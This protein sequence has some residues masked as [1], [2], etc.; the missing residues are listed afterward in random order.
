MSGKRKIAI[1]GASGS[2]G[3]NALR[4][5]RKN[6]DTLEIVAIAGGSRVEPLVEIAQEFSVPE[7]TVFDS[8]NQ[9][10]NDLHQLFP[11][12]TQVSTGM[13]GLIRMV[14]LEQVDMVLIAIVGTTALLP[15]IEAIQHKKMIALASKEILVMAGEFIMPLLKKHDGVLLP[16]DSE[17]NAIFQC[18]NGEKTNEIHKIII[19]AS[20][21]RYLNTPVEELGEIT[22]DEA[23]KHPNWDMGQKISIDSST[24]ANKGLEVIEAKWLFGLTPD[25]I[26]VT[27]HPQSIIHSMVQYVDGAILAQMSPPNMSFAIQNCLL[28]P[29][30]KPG[31]DPALD[32]SSAFSLD[33]QKPDRTRFPCL[34]LA[35][36]ALHVG[37]TAPAVFNAANEI[38]V[39][40]FIEKRISYLDI[41]RLIDFT[42]NQMNIQ[43]PSSIEDIIATD[44]EARRISYHWTLS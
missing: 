44:E 28:Y 24:M 39:N 41:P 29:Q 18:L 26:D 32:F 31:I 22:A 15:C 8:G 11:S 42:L 1:L 21:G 19:T 20:G 13:E 16:T 34:Q 30:R 6:L 27:I 5:I 23:V 40:A 36:D 38:A 2:I 10:L 3:M 9:S 7:V 4:V 35:F 14:T 43:Q 25:Q 12:G 37:K 33:F 17:H